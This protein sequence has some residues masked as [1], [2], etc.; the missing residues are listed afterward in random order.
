MPA[1]TPSRTAVQRGAG[2]L[3]KKCSAPSI[4]IQREAWVAA[5][6]AWGEYA[7]AEPLCREALQIRQKVLGPEH[8]VT[9]TS[10]EINLAA[11][12]GI[13][14]NTPRPN[15][16]YQEALE[17][18]QKVLGPENPSIRHS[19]NLAL[20]YEDMGEYS[21]A[22][23]LCIEA[24]EIRQKVLGHEH[25]QTAQSL[26]NLA[27]LYKAMGEYA[28]AEPLLKEVFEIQQKCSAPSNPIL[29][30]ASTIWRSFTNPCASTPKQNPL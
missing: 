17:I 26:D 11:L 28:K 15:H 21:K 18:R 29:R 30:R 23:P 24:L 8:P 4:P 16:L 22:E 6:A 5:L 12:Y 14:V 3:R 13:W 19:D 9:G 27:V 1:N 10:L 20:L 7:K 2:D 25:P